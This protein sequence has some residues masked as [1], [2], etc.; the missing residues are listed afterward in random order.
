M[1]RRSALFWVSLDMEYGT[2]MGG[3]TSKSNEAQRDHF[4]KT[5]KD[6]YQRLKFYGTAHF[7]VASL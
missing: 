4:G 1:D 5:H 3:Q 6:A 2:P 7:P